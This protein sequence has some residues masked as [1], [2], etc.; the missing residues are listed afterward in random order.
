MPDKYK[1]SKELV[2]EIKEVLESR[3]FIADDDG[4]YSDEEVIRVS[5][6]LEEELKGQK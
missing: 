1:L 6:K 5:K 3:W 4:E 2:D